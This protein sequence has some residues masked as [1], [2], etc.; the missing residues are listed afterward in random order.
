MFL[1]LPQ[2][3]AGVVQFGHALGEFHLIAKLEIV[4]TLAQSPS[5]LDDRFL[6]VANRLDGGIDFLLCFLG[7]AFRLAERE[8]ARQIV[9]AF[10]LE[11]CGLRFF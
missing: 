11:R 10:H 1:E 6:T 8:A 5:G 9:E 3:L 7:V 2:A 4:R